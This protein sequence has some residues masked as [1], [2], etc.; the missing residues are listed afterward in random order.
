MRAKVPYDSQAMMRHLVAR[1]R[2]KRGE[3]VVVLDVRELADYMDYLVIATARG[4]RQCRAIADDLVRSAR[5]EGA[6]P[7]S[8]AGVEAGAWICI[9]FVDVVVHVF[10]PSTRAHYDLEL[11]WADAKRVEIQAEASSV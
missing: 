7:L 4:E 1:C 8:E 10:T 6:R 2:E 5:H 9:D 11:L 3:D